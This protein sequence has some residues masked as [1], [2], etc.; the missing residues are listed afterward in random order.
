MKQMPQRLRGRVE[1]GLCPADVAAKYVICRI[2]VVP[3][4]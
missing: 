3:G 2:F 1:P 4:R